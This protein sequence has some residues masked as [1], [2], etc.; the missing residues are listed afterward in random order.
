MKYLWEEFDSIQQSLFS[1]KAKLFLLDFDGTL[2][3]IA[4]TPDAARLDEE[5]K[6]ILTTLNQSPR[7][8]LAIVS[9]RSLKELSS[10]VRL[11]NVIYAGNHGL[12]IKGLNLRLPPRA[13][14]AR[15]LKG[16]IKLLAQKFKMAFG[17]YE[18][19]LVEDKDFTLSLHFRKLMPEQGLL[20][21]ELV[22]FF[23]EKYKK[24][25]VI[26]VKGKKVWEVRPTLYWTKGD[27][28][29]YLLKKFPG[30][31]PIVIGDDRSDEDMFTVIRRRGITIR[32]G[33]LRDSQA[34]YY[35]KSPRDVKVFLKKL[36]H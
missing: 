32:V 1:K 16:F 31:F 5:I 17:D 14:K 12:E 11:K 18:G 23:K 7:H 25:P 35:L 15:R 13:R 33:R 3:P 26:W 21:N 9:G 29:L 8:T 28:V 24:Y 22:G 4:S 19:V 20:F 36:C 10:M 34:E 2:A 27:T 6:Q 30:V